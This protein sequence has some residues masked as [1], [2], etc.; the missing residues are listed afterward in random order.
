M[1]SAPLTM[2]LPAAA[3]FPPR[4][5]IGNAFPGGAVAG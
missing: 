4:A 3:P 1:H 5:D 2:G